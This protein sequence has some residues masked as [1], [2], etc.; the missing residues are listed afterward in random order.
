MRVLFASPPG[1]RLHNLVPLAWALRSAGHEAQIAAGSA[2]VDAV[3]RTGLVAVDADGTDA[4]VDYAGLW[5]AD[6]VIWDP[7]SPA[8]A[9]AA[10]GVGAVGVRMRGIPDHEAPADAEPVHAVATVDSTPPTLRT[11]PADGPQ[12]PIRYVPYDGPAVVPSWLRRNPRRPRVY[13]SLS[14]AGTTLPELFDALDGLDIEA[15]CAIPVDLVPPDTDLPQT[16]RLVDS[17]PLN[18]VLPTCAAV[19][20]DG[21]VRAAAAAYGVPQLVIDA[22]VDRTEAPLAKRIHHVVTD[23]EL[24]ADADRLRAEVSAMPSPRDVVPDLVRLVRHGVGAL[25]AA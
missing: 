20:H 25:G 6:L 16:V 22:D 10:R 5:R 11:L 17:V 13:V 2:G 3:N 8:G 19:V 14:G 7:R 21:A 12:L 1:Q 18:A 24:R 9:V 15:I 23:P 4:L